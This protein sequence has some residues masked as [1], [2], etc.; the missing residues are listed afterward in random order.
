[1]WLCAGRRLPRPLDRSHLIPSLWEICSPKWLIIFL[2]NSKPLSLVPTFLMEPKVD[3]QLAKMICFVQVSSW[4]D[5]CRWKINNA[6]SK[7]LVNCRRGGGHLAGF[8]W[9]SFDAFAFHYKILNGC[10]HFSHRLLMLPAT[11][12]GGGGGGHFAGFLWFSF[13]AFAFHYK[14]LNGCWHFSHRLLMLPAT[15]CGVGAKCSSMVR[16]LAHGAMDRW[17]DPS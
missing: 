2:I 3:C 1:M 4:Y 15:G 16:V 12:W 7:I 10:W 11:G 8:L 17:I 9:F 14:I 5:C 13:D 6:S